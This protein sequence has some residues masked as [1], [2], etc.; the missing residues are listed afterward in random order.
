MLSDS[1]IGE[2]RV[3]LM[4]V[5]SDNHYSLRDGGG[6]GL[7]TVRSPIFQ[8]MF[9]ANS[10]CNHLSFLV[11]CYCIFFVV[12]FLFHE[13]WQLYSYFMSETFFF[14]LINS[15]YTYSIT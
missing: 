1:D 3:D 12:F 2:G 6:G 14:C 8:L 15:Y 10:M 5:G 13:Y 11:C 7:V 9:L 4:A